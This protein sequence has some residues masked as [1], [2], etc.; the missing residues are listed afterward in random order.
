METQF[1]EVFY[2][3]SLGTC[4]EASDKVQ[5]RCGYQPRQMTYCRSN[6]KLASVRLKSSEGLEE[7]VGATKR[8]LVP[9]AMT[10][11]YILMSYSELCMQLLLL[12]SEKF[13]TRFQSL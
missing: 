5:H 12:Y 8:R 13:C 7:I 11:G 1:V 9:Y 3:F 4:T 2:D 10:S 6:V